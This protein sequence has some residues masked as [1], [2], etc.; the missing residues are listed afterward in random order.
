MFQ[1]Y[2]KQ[3]RRFGVEILESLIEQPGQRYE[4]KLLTEHDA[5]NLAP[6]I[7]LTIPKGTIITSLARDTLKKRQIQ[8]R[9]ETEGSL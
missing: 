9:F 8:L 2:L 3:L 4:K 7:C 1:D 5:F 6:L